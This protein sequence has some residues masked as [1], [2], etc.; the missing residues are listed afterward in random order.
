MISTFLISATKRLPDGGLKS[1]ELVL[2][3]DQ[4][5]M[6]VEPI[7]VEQE[8]YEYGAPQPSEFTGG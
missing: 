8:S 3:L 2:Q 7:Q 1:C 4:D 6:M 5:G